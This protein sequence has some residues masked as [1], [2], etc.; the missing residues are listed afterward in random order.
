MRNISIN[1]RT[2]IYYLL[3]IGVL[4]LPLKFMAYWL[5]SVLV[6]EFFHYIAIIILGG[7][8]YQLN[9]S[10]FGMK[11]DTSPL[12]NNQE[13]ICAIAGPLGGLLLCFLTI[14]HFPLLG[15]LS[16]A[17]SVY[18]MIPLFPLDGGRVLH[19]LI[20]FTGH[21]KHKRLITRIDKFVSVALLVTAG[22]CTFRLSLG[23]LPIIIAISMIFKNKKAKGTCIVSKF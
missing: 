2:E 13:I 23:F 9:I 12:S 20:R 21:K 11:M 8:I 18:N 5:I 15:L 17:H 7:H 14:T 4:I 10:I 3:C 19:G 6:H 1:I 16:L 22:Y